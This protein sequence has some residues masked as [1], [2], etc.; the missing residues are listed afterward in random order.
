MLVRIEYS[1]K[2]LSQN[3]ILGTYLPSS[4][5]LTPLTTTLATL[6]W[7]GSLCRLGW[8]WTLHLPSSVSWVLRLEMYMPPH[9]VAFV[10][11]TV[12]QVPSVLN[13]LW[14]VFS[15]ALWCFLSLEFMWKLRKLI[16]SEAGVNGY[17]FY[18]RFSLP[19]L[20]SFLLF[21]CHFY[22]ASSSHWD[23]RSHLNF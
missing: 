21:C 9:R 23:L 1:Y 16:R 8:H 10:V 20:F 2:Y 14:S 13:G 11:L 17:L 19:W 22:E 15:I 3:L 7:N 5:P 6:S 18:T 4:L 12:P